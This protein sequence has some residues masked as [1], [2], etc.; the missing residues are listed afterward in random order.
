MEKIIK[1]L[2]KGWIK[3]SKT[4]E[5]LDHEMPIAKWCAGVLAFTIVMGAVTK[6]KDTSVYNMPTRELIHKYYGYEYKPNMS[7]EEMENKELEKRKEY[8]FGYL[9]N[10]T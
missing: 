9:G 5:K 6:P 8:P 10:K 4:C 7:P 1:S 2:L 3:I